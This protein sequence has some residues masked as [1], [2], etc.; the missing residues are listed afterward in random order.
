M[1]DQ[2]YASREEL[3]AELAAITRAEIEALMA[4]GVQYVQL[5]NPGYGKYLGSHAPSGPRSRRAGRVRA[6]GGH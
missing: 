3:G 2:F 1:T 5:D 6:H 4:E